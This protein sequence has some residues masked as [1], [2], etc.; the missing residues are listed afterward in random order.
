LLDNLPAAV[1]VRRG[2]GWAERFVGVGAAGFAYVER[3][4][5][6]EV[7]AWAD[8]HAGK[9]PEGG[10]VEVQLAAN[11]WLHRALGLLDDG[12]V[13]VI[14][15]GDTADGLATRRTEG[16]L[17]TYSGHHLGPD[18]LHE[19]G[20]TDITVD[21]D[22]GALQGVAEQAGASVTLSTQREFLVEWGL[23]DRLAALRVREV[24]LAGSGD[25][26]ERLRVRDLL[27]GGEALLHPRGLGDFRVLVGWV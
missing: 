19:P 18:P 1:A 9:V 23:G 15:Y 16:T 22:F 14:D 27:T 13:V 26:L 24:E 20:A 7:A 8:R 11:E 6:A 10:I 4:A 21:V 2:G 17:R 12:A 25:P 3:D 5:R